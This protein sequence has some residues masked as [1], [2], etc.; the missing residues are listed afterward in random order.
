MLLRTN[1]KK[2]DEHAVAQQVVHLVLADA[3]AAGQ[4]Q[5]RGLLVGRVVVDVHVRVAL[6][7]LAHHRQE[8]DQRL[9]LARAGRAPTAAGSPP[10][11][12]HAEQVLQA[13]RHAVGGPQRVALEVEE[14]V[15]GVGIRAAPERLRVGDLERRLAVSRSAICSARLC[16]S[17]T[18][19][20]APSTRAR[21][22][23]VREPG[24]RGDARRRSAGALGHPHTGHQQQVVVV[25]DLDRALGQRK[26]ARTSSSPQRTA[27]PPARWPSSSFQRGALLAVHRQ[28]VVDAVVD[29]G[30]VAEHQLDLGGATAHPW[31]AA[32]RRSR[33]AAAA[34]RP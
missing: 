31:R 27:Q 6:A 30:A 12:Q 18:R 22:V 7:P 17:A 8:V 3:V 10:A 9:A 11:L 21:G 20:S 26:H 13:P 5:Q 14:Q 2:V 4:P 25:A 32:H 15:A 1:G 23:M 24:H 29:S 34:P 16:A 19:R 28:Q 33:R